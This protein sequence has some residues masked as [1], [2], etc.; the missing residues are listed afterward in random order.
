MS[1]GVIL[2]YILLFSINGRGNELVIEA[3]T[4][5]YCFEFPSLAEDE[6]RNCINNFRTLYRSENMED[7]EAFMQE[8]VMIFIKDLINN[9][10]SAKIYFQNNLKAKKEIHDKEAFMN[11]QYKLFNC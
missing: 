10:E 2:S 6:I 8:P 11:N 3:I 9:D 5:Y 7:L 4:K 1:I